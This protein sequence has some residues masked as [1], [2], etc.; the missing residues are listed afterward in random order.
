MKTDA[1]ETV[2]HDAEH[3]GGTYQ[4][5]IEQAR[6]QLS[7]LV[8]ANREMREALKPFARWK[9]SFTERRGREPENAIARLL[10]KLERLD[11]STA[12]APSESPR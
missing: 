9:P 8:E 2:L 7:A 10:E 4:H 3:G 12:P 6:L 1:I 11:A 5:T